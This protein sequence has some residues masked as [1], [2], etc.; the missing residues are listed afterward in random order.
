M[1]SPIFCWVILSKSLQGLNN[2]KGRLPPETV[3]SVCFLILECCYYLTPF[4]MTFAQRLGQGVGLK[5]SVL[6]DDALFAT[7]PIRQQE[8]CT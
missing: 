6:H 8:M 3:T 7:P 2:K 4:A 5:S 1:F